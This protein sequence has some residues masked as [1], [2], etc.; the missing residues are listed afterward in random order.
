MNFPDFRSCSFFFQCMY[1][2]SHFGIFIS[3]RFNWVR[4]ITFCLR[5]INIWPTLL[6]LYFPL[7]LFI[8]LSWLSQD[9]AHTHTPPRHTHITFDKLLS[10]PTQ[11]NSLSLTRQPQ[12]MWKTKIKSQKWKNPNKTISWTN[13]LHQ[14]Q[15]QHQLIS[16]TVS[17]ICEFHWF[18]MLISLSLLS[19][20]QQLHWD[21]FFW[22]IPLKRD[23]P[24]IAGWSQQSNDQRRSVRHSLL[25]KCR[26]KAPAEPERHLGPG[27][28]T[29]PSG[30]SAMALGTGT[31]DTV[32][33]VG[34]VV[35][36]CHLAI[37]GDGGAT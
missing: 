34:T 26:P 35:L 15:H 4:F 10:S 14:H 2:F 32:D 11:L 22:C 27:R 17:L 33:I 29:A 16:Q 21:A 12:R 24:H 19:V 9:V 23:Q 28:P 30:P 8:H 6:P 36:S 20:E 31:V 37:G 3:L 18:P 13:Q 5:W 7:S 1:E 25:F